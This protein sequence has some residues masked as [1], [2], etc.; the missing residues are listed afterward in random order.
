MVSNVD[1]CN[2]ALN[3]IGGSNIIAL[4]E[5]S[6][7]GRLCNQR[8][9]FVRDAVF[10]AHPWNCLIKRASLPAETD[11]PAFEFSSQFSLPNDPYCLRVIRPQDPDTVYRV[12]GRKILS[13]TAP[14]PVIYLAR[15][16]DPN[17]YDL[18][19][20]ETIAARLAADLAY[21]LVNSS[22][23]AQLMFTLYESKLS[24]ARFTDATEGTPDNLVNIDRTNFSESDLL[25]NSRL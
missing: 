10:R 11:T 17:E 6:K 14:F 18:L 2:S 5:D 24:E 20:V 7:A 9:E 16:T 3:Q 4:T 21:P 23:L 12:E 1:I 19:L 22:A 8:Y 13:D 15:V 25:I